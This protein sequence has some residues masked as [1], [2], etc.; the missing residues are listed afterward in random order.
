MNDDHNIHKLTEEALN[1]LDGINR[2]EPRPFLYTRLSARM[3]RPANIWE[4]S[5]R[6][7]SRPV[8]AVAC[9]LLVF[10][11]NGIVLLN[12]KTKQPEQNELLADDFTTSEMNTRSSVLFDMEQ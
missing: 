1:S 2:A 7:L 6:Y 10:L 3:Q 4:R 11:V 9:L 12:N 8:V 5:A